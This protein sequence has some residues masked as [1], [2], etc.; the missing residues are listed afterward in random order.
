VLVANLPYNTAVP[1]VLHLLGIA[2]QLRRVVVMV[3]AEV[4]R[5]LAAPPGTKDYGSP[6]V[7][8]R[9]YGRWQVAAPVSRQVF[10]PVPH[11]DSLLVA[12]EHTPPPGDE[13][14]RR[15]VWRLVEQAFHTRRKMARG[16]LAPMLGEATSNLIEA[17]GLDPEDRGEAWSLED[18]VA[19]AQI[20]RSAG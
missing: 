8:A 6:S 7:K 11:V 17:A 4:A 13:E 18:Y 19:L 15:V 3:Q 16:A 9:W 5:R 14:L 1:I 2:P 10:W 12:M 20:V